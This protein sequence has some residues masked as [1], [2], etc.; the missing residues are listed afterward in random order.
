M[1][2]SSS[3]IV[4]EAL[5]ATVAAGRGDANSSV[6]RATAEL[7]RGAVVGR[8]LVLSKLGAGGMGVVFAGHD[9]ELDRKVALK[10]LHPRLAVDADPG[11]AAEARTRL[12]R[13]AQALAK[14]NHPNIVAI[15]DVGEH[16]GAVWL[17][18]EYVDGE[19]L[20]AWSRQR[21]RTWREVLDVTTPAARGLAAAHEA[22]LVHRDIKPD[23]IMIGRD[24]RVRVMDLGLARALGGDAGA[25]R[26]SPDA[27]TAVGRELAALSARV[28]QVGSVLGTPAY[29]SPEQ[30]RGQAVDVRA[31][32][33]SF[34][35]M[36]WE[37]LMGER[38]FAGDTLVEL[39]AHVL[40]GAVRPVPRDPYARRVPGWLRR[41]CLRGLAAE[42]ERRFASMTA[43]LDALSRGRKRARAR[44]WLGGAAA[45]AIVGA[46]PALV[47]R[48]ER[49][50]RAAACEAAGAAVDGVWNDEARAAVRRGI[51]ATG[52]G[53]AP[54]TADRVMPILDRQADAWREHRTRVCRMADLEGTLDAETVDRAVWCLD[55]R[56]MELAALVTEL[57]RADAT[58]VQ[59][60]VTAAAGLPPVSPCGDRQV[61]ATLP[62]PP[63]PRDK[64]DAVRTTL[65]QARTSSWTGK[66]ADGL[67]QVRAALADAEALGWPPLTAAATQLEGH[68]LERSGDY[69]GAEVA[70]LAAYMTAAKVQAWDTAATAAA[71]LVLVVGSHQ[72][73]HAE[74]K[75]WAGHA[76]VA[77]ALAGSP[78]GLGEARRL[79]YLAGVHR[80]T[81]AYA[82][83]K[84]LHERALALREQAL[85]PEHPAVAASLT[86]LAMVRQAMGAYAE[87][88]ALHERALAIRETAL[89]PGH[90]DVAASLTNLA[91]VAHQAAGASP[92]VKALYERALAIQEQALGLEHPD[93]A[94]TLNNLGIFY[95]VTGASAE[96]RALFERTRAIR[97]KALGP[98]H[99]SVAAVLDNLASVDVTTG[100][101][102]D[103]KLLYGRALA[104]REKALGPEHPDVAVTL[105]NLA[106][107]HV[108]MGAYAEAKR[109]HARALAIRERALGPGHPAVADSLGNLGNIALLQ[110]V[111]A[112]ARTLLERAVAIYD[113]HAG[114]QDHEPLARFGLARA[115]VRTGGDRAR[116]LAEAQK[117]ADG[118]RAAGE[119]K[120]RKL[121]EVE[122]FLAEVRGPAR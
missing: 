63:D 90:P 102:A 4:D 91:G 83:A 109:L 57:S 19:T 14:L 35:V 39:A 37:A 73:R 115:L 47:A 59:R 51:V 58:V 100:A 86:G 72:A 103:A 21:R 88:R 13:E 84:L 119:G 1:T 16:A 10:L 78:A 22:G 87:A 80:A 3:T 44:W 25:G 104:I 38:P 117:A 113:A 93:V 110:D 17:A 18:M 23:N 46:S 42:P 32:V 8:Y 62:T 74:G 97:E 11:A 107:V 48:H 112:E 15:H 81:G 60:A 68:L 95:Q 99:P 6:A 94:V 111:P 54:V 30:L 5:G 7:E 82:E 45:L 120:A 55:E 27:P 77:L 70:G 29:M 79:G 122:A 101:D 106:A 98:E 105:N 52:L 116:A 65:S 20:S 9:P 108:H 33:F 66:Y 71:D 12:A 28:T 85:G 36:L 69:R 64:V 41:V 24:G 31:D 75:V 118:L 96:A 89:G 114:V 92:E 2:L 67:K 53:Y 49:A 121:A 43:L 56:R 34:C 76:E 40:T 50:G 26:V 61:L